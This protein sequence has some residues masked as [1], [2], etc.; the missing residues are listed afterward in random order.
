MDFID[1]DAKVLSIDDVPPPLLPIVHLGVEWVKEGSKWCCKVED[2]I[3]KYNMKWLLI[4]CLKKMHNL[5]VEKGKIGCLSTHPKGPK[6]QNH[7]TMNARVFSDPIMIMCWNK[8][9]VATCTRITIVAKWDWLQKIAK[10]LKQAKKPP[11][12]K[13]A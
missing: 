12:I 1:Q 6:Q 13:V 3:K 5:V 7:T 9:K 11:L 4:A 8:Q 10:D 2:Y